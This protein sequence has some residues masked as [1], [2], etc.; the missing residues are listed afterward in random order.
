[1]F[2]LTPFVRRNHIA[3][4]D[5]FKDLDAMERA[6]FGGS[7]QLSGSVAEKGFFGYII[8]SVGI[9][10]VVEMLV[11]SLVTGALGVALKKASLL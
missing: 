5:P 1:M 2:E 6:F 8:A 10:A 3:T 9:N 4:F 7:E 11:A